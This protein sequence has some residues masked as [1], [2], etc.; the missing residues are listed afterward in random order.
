MVLGCKEPARLFVDDGVAGQYKLGEE[1]VGVDLVNRLACVVAV[2]AVNEILVIAIALSGSSS[3]REAIRCALFA[4]VHDDEL[5]RGSTLFRASDVAP[6]A[7]FFDV[8]PAS[9]EIAA[10]WLVGNLSF[11]FFDGRSAHVRWAIDGAAGIPPVRARVQD[12]RASDRNEKK[13][14]VSHECD[15]W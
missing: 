2:N 15:H 9:V 14:C 8:V 12:E 13:E 1:L 10:R 6:E 7:G 11:A 5:G 4:F 3:F